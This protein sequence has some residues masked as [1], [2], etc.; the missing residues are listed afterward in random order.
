MAFFLAFKEIWR[1]QVRFLSFSAVIALITVLVLFIAAL[2]QG[3][4]MAN[5]EY[6]S[7]V[8]GD[9]IVFNKNADRM[10]SSSLIRRSN[11][12]DI[13]RVD[14][15]AD[16]GSVGFSTGKIL[17]GS[18]GE[19]LDVSLIGVDP[20]KP[21]APPVLEGQSFSNNRSSEVII[22]ANVAEDSGLQVG[23]KITIVTI[24]NDEET[25]NT[26]PIVG[27]TDGQQYLYAGSVF[28]TNNTWDKIRSTGAA[29]TG[30]TELTSNVVI[31]KGE[32]PDEAELVAQQIEN[33]V[34]GT[35]V[36][37]IQTAI[38]ALPGY[39]AQ[40][41]TLNTQQAF[42]LLIGILVIGGFFQIQML[43]KIPQI[44]VL[45]AI[46]TTNSVVAH[47][48]VMQIILITT[49]GVFIGAGI[50]FLLATFLPAGIPILFSGPSVLLAVIS[51]LLIGPIGGLVSVRLAIS[52]EPLIAL[53]L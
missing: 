35:D 20:N 8:D 11:L 2:A 18:S 53:R 46:G 33:Q 24:R 32:N 48:V 43:Q 19:F 4:A 27:I 47:S 3:L 34:S 28:L 9:L 15:V 29:T 37:D 36:V 10:A 17:L 38:E 23:D 50:T 21:G 26:L 30:L 14:G 13:T 6:L 39:S 22:D 44:G 16:A 1:N 7:K 52:V 45:K 49:F 40:Q 5:K 31:V 41:S 25:Y 12:N 51:L 42:T